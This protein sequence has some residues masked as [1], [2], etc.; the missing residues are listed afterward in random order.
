MAWTIKMLGKNKHTKRTHKQTKNLKA[1]HDG[2]MMCK[3]FDCASEGGGKKASEGLVIVT[4]VSPVA[5]N[6]TDVTVRP[7][8]AFGAMVGGVWRGVWHLSLCGAVLGVMEV[9]TIADVT[10]QPWGELLFNRLFVMAVIIIQLT[11]I[12]AV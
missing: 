10:E 12:I 3:Y 5:E 6:L 4:G 7:F 11:W 1:P 2:N 8:L 9:E